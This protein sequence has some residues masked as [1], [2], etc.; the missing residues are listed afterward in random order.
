MLSFSWIISLSLYYFMFQAVST[1]ELRLNC[2][3]NPHEYCCI[4]ISLITSK[5]SF[6]EVNPWFN[7][8]NSM[9]IWWFCRQQICD[10]KIAS[11]HPTPLIIFNPIVA[12]L[13]H[14][15]PFKLY[16]FGQRPKKKK[17]RDEEW[18]NSW[19]RWQNKIKWMWCWHSSKKYWYLWFVKTNCFVYYR[20]FSLELPMKARYN[21][22]RFRFWQPANSGI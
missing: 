22:T 8:Q 13:M 16:C 1:S 4:N 20:F 12:I 6:L 11:S 3:E 17:K 18:Q 7:F 2:T 21:A 5:G 15:L 14:F 19:S 10:H 9:L